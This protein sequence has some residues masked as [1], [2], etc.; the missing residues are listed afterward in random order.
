MIGVD[1]YSIASMSGDE[2]E[3]NYIEA[4]KKEGWCDKTVGKK[5]VGNI[6]RSGGKEINNA[7]YKESTIV[8]KQE[9]RRVHRRTMK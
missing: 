5:E 2:V 6:I 7:D 4:G 1:E 8:S 9:D 3:E